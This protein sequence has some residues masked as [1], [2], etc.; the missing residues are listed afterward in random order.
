MSK[1]LVSLKEIVTDELAK[2]QSPAKKEAGIFR[3]SSKADS[4]QERS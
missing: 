3:T 1:Q 4:N 2:L